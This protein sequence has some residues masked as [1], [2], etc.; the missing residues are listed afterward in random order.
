VCESAWP[1][2]D[3]PGQSLARS[4]ESNSNASAEGDEGTDSEASHWQAQSERPVAVWTVSRRRPGCRVVGKEPRATF[5][6]RLSWP[7]RQQW[8]PSRP[9]RQAAQPQHESSLAEQTEFPPN[10][11]DSPDL[12]TLIPPQTLVGA[13]ACGAT[14]TYCMI[15]SEGPSTSRPWFR[16]LNAQA[17]PT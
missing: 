11:V 13:S 17:L 9:L 7:D 15:D 3:W 4:R 14:S 5:C 16:H 8:Q 2:L 10:D 6:S 12:F 1:C